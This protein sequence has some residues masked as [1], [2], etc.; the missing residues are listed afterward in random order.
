MFGGV[1]FFRFIIIFI[2]WNGRYPV[3]CL[4]APRNR[5]FPRTKPGFVTTTVTFIDVP[6]VL[7]GKNC[8]A[9]NSCH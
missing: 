2:P 9:I 3:L 8:G 7:R 4:F 5:N 1:I 6:N